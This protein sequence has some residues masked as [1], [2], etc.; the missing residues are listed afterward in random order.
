LR[1]QPNSPTDL[2][3]G[4]ARRF[5]VLEEIDDDTYFPIYCAS[6]GT[7]YIG[8][9]DAGLIKFDGAE[10]RFYTKENGL[11]DSQINE[12][13]EDRF[14]N[15]WIASNWGAMK[16]TANGFV[17]YKS[18]DGLADERSLGIFA[19][20]DAAIYALHSNWR[21]SRFD[22]KRFVSAAPKLPPEAGAWDYHRMML[23]TRG[24]WWVGT[25]KG[26][27]RFAT[28]GQFENL[29]RASP[30]AKFD[31]QSGLPFENILGIFEDSGGDVWLSFREDEAKGFLS[32]WDRASGEVENFT[33]ADGI[34]AD[35]TPSHFREDA[36]GNLIILC[37]YN[38][39]LVRRGENFF[40]YTTAELQK[41]GVIHRTLVDGKGRLW[42]ATPLG[43]LI[44][45]DNPAS[46]NPEQKVYTALD[47]L[48]S[49]HVQYLAE[50][51]AGKIYL[52]TSRAMDRLDPKT[53]EIKHFTLAD[54]L[55]A[56][57]SGAATRDHTGALW[58]ATTRGAARFVPERSEPQTPPPVYI[59]NLRIAGEAQPI[60]VLGESEIKI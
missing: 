1:F 55:P 46:D 43:G 52:V 40:S 45:F 19:G 16:V 32:R 30:V 57:G 8:T 34:P 7:V 39:V 59:G 12:I 47:G 4:F 3:Q 44:R 37:R 60:S 50:D 13:R 26:V 10:F 22:G 25:K 49:S 21:V 2:P 6:N 33:P 5:D 11:S 14:G 56:A 51:S 54:G 23:D 41:S 15:L 53:G 58:L 24:E 38:S 20:A 17:S 36:V 9:R 27:F 28:G 42:I 29:A 48:S 18:A 35:C 31:K